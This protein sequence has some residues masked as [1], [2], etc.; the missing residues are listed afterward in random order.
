MRIGSTIAL[1]SVVAVVG[2]GGD[3]N[4]GD[5]DSGTGTSAAATDLRVTVRAEGPDGKAAVHTVECD[6]S[7]SR[8]A[9]CRRLTTKRLAPVPGDVACTQV[10][11]GP[12]T[13]RVEGTLRG[14][15]VDAR[16][17]LTNGCE[18][19]RWKRNAALLGQPPGNPPGG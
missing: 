3:G 6:Q 5:G 1:L 9:L 13:A 4:S 2:C 17:D 14:R 18:I 11:G 8:S 12:A 16:F 19:A 10:F 15:P 7:G